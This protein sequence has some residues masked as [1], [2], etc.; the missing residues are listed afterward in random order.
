M[1][2]WT[3]FGSWVS[4]NTLSLI[5]A[6][7]SAQWLPAARIRSLGLRS[8]Q[9]AITSSSDFGYSVLGALGTTG[10]EGSSCLRSGRIVHLLI[11]VVDRG[12]WSVLPA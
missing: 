7:D 2:W 9:I 5:A 12:A 6:S 10:T 3:L 8:R 4:T 1:A 11:G